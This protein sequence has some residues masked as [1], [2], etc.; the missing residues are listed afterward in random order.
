[1]ASTAAEVIRS[2]GLQAELP[3]GPEPPSWWSWHFPW[4]LELPKETADILLVVLLCLAAFLV[5]LFIAHA[6]GDLL[7]VWR[8][9][10]EA[11][12]VPENG[13]AAVRPAADVMIAADELARQGRFV[14]AIHTLLLQGLADIRQR[15]DEQFADSLTSR[16]ILRSARLPDRGRA[17]LRDLIAR[18]EWT[19]FGEH[20]A[21]AADYAACR[22]SFGELAQAL[23]R[24]APA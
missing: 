24:E 11:V 10:A 20:P 12:D 4:H 7:S 23:H 13:E 9:R 16:E 15:L 3:L 14:E 6:R 8:R 18:V 1:M 19:Y 22:A 17:P 2:L 5:F 21:G